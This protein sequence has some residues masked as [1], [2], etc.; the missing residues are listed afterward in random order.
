M[1]LIEVSFNF[2]PPESNVF[3]SCIMVFHNFWAVDHKGYY[4]CC[5]SWMK[6]DG[7]G[8]S[9]DENWLAGDNMV[10]NRYMSVGWIPL[11]DI[12]TIISVASKT[13]KNAHFFK[14]SYCTLEDHTEEELWACFESWNWAAPVP[15]VLHSPH[16][17]PE[18]RREW[19]HPQSRPPQH[20]HHTLNN[21][22]QQMFQIVQPMSDLV[23]CYGP[24][25]TTRFTCLVL[26]PFEHKPYKS[27]CR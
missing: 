21:S 10:I 26:V 6:T 11:H 1:K 15:T 13:F 9:M 23:T 24:Q 12:T 14:M 8:L 4:T 20:T 25:A 3:R 17:T 2:L 22:F 16:P 7:R 18:T 27:E 19:N 5:W